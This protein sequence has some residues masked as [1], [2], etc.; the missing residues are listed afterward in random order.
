MD[1]LLALKRFGDGFE[2]YHKP[3]FQSVQNI[4]L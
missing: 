4:A 2:I 1:I 3:L